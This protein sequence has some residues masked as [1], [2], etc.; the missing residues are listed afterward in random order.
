M[1]SRSLLLAAA[2]A[3]AGCIDVPDDGGLNMCDEDSDCDTANGEVCANHICW[4]DP[5]A[6]VF[7]ARVAPPAGRL[8]LVTTDYP[9]ISMQPDGWF[10]N[11][12]LEEPITLSGSVYGECPPAIG[13]AD[14]RVSIAANITITR[15]AR[16]DGGPIFVTTTMSEAGVV[17]GDGESYSVKLPRAQAGESYIITVAAIDDRNGAETLPPARQSLAQIVEDTTVDFE[18]G[19]APRIVTGR[20]LNEFGAAVGGWTVKARGK[21]DDAAMTLTD[22]SGEAT[23]DLADGTF[24]LY[25]PGNTQ[26]LIEVWAEPPEG[27]PIKVSLVKTLML[28]GTQTTTGAGVME[29]P[30][31]GTGTMVTIPVVGQTGSGFDDVVGAKVTLTTTM[32]LSESP[33]PPGTLRGEYTASDETDSAGIAVVPILGETHIYRMQITPPPGAN[34]SRYGTIY[35][36]PAEI[37]GAGPQAL[38]AVQLPPQVAVTGI[39]TDWEMHPV[40]GVTVTVVPNSTFAYDLPQDISRQLDEIVPPSVSTNRNGEFSVFVDPEVAGQPA[41]YDIRFDPGPESGLP[42]WHVSSVQLDITEGMDLAV[43]SLPPAAHVRS[44]VY[45]SGDTPLELEGATVQIYEIP[46][47]VITCIQTRSC[48]G[49]EKAILRAQ[50]DSQDDDGLGTG[51]VH[52]VLPDP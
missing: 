35:D 6:G 33:D 3:L 41:L 37:A 22:I 48:E 7:A 8:D 42:S 49:G 17:E 9:M 34:D 47:A 12:V 27:G 11:L 38:A 13:C 52:L 23:S 4:G 32:D 24:S 26:P 25:L 1:Y 18:L 21:W 20:L 15:A 39:L 2:C 31:Y 5:P 51:V 43:I 36:A 50:A 28:S 29:V 46:A 19:V 10:E 40:E 30:D 16:I 44:V 14:P 45:E